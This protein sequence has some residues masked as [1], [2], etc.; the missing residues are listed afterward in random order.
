MTVASSAR[1]TKEKAARGADGF[2]RSVVGQALVFTTSDGASNGRGSSRDP[3]PP[4][5]P[6]AAIVKWISLTLAAVGSST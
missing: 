1:Y 5:P 6:G 2:S 4:P 3:G